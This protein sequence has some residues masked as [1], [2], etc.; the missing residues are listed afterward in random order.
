[1]PPAA[2]TLAAR[3]LASLHA[4][5]AAGGPIGLLLDPALLSPDVAFVD[6]FGT[7]LS[8]ERAPRL[9]SRVLALLTAPPV[10]A[11]REALVRASDR[12]ASCHARELG[13]PE[14]MLRWVPLR[15][16]ATGPDE[17]L[18]AWEATWLPQPM[19]PLVRAGR[20]AR[21]MRVKIRSARVM[22]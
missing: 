12:W 7:T 16:T 13:T 20:C 15:V 22:C 17:L 10:T 6:D 9:G 8:G 19:L 14:Q 5:A 3:V 2:D 21:G 4:S 1:M 11:G 18:V